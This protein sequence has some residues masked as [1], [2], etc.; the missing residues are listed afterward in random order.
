[1]KT[2]YRDNEEVLEVLA[3]EEFEIDLFRKYSKYYGYVF[4]LLREA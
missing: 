3:L 2:K 4:Y 1:M